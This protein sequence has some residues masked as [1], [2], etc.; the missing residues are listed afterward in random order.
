MPAQTNAGVDLGPIDRLVFAR[1]AS[2][3]PVRRAFA[4]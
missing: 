1:C 3:D 4:D 2:L